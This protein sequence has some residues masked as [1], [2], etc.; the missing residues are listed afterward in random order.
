MLPQYILSVNVALRYFEAMFIIAFVLGYVQSSY[1]INTRVML[2]LIDVGLTLLDGVIIQVTASEALAFS[3]LRLVVMYYAVAAIQG[4]NMAALSHTLEAQVSHIQACSWPGD[5]SAAQWFQ[6]FG[7]TITFLVVSFGHEYLCRKAFLDKQTFSVEATH[8]RTSSLYPQSVF[9]VFNEGSDVAGPSCMATTPL[10]S[11]TAASVV[12]STMPAPEEL[13]AMAASVTPYIT[14][15]P[16]EPSVIPSIMA[17]TPEDLSASKR[18]PVSAPS[19]RPTA[20]AAVGEPRGGDMVGELRGGEILDLSQEGSYSTIQ[21]GALPKQ[22]ENSSQYVNF[23][24]T[25]AGYA[26]HA[27]GGHSTRVVRKPSLVA[28]ISECFF[29]FAD[30]AMEKQYVTLQ[31]QQRSNA[32]LV[33]CVGFCATSIYWL[34]KIEGLGKNMVGCILLEPGAPVGTVFSLLAILMGRWRW[35][36]PG[37]VVGNSL[38]LLSLA[39]WMWYAPAFLPASTHRWAG[40]ISSIGLWLG[41]A[42]TNA[43][44]NFLWNIRFKYGLLFALIWMAMVPSYVARS[45]I[46]IYSW[47][48]QLSLVIVTMLRLQIELKARSRFLNS[49]YPTAGSKLALTAAPANTP[50]TSG[51]HLPAADLVFTDAFFT[52][53]SIVAGQESHFS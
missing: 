23:R 18:V 15:D 32:I 47:P 50:Y 2:P 36:E 9:G 1:L 52:Y 43:T 48:L 41:F 35:V 38:R 45:S 37:I 26:A 21:A 13:S 28:S 46:I 14:A 51:T 49:Y 17:A 7:S 8:S 10:P 24:K 42:F 31:A 53:D 25:L 5:L 16:A 11:I 27:E 19:I 6:I 3:P 12:P 20:A 44:A 29:G 33:M 22:A 4:C 34:W 30:C 40:P 39:V